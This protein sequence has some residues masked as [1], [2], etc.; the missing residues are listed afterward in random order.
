MSPCINMVFVS[1]KKFI[2]RSIPHNSGRN[3]LNKK[4][5]CI[6]SSTTSNV[7]KENTFS[8]YTN[9]N[10]FSQDIIIFILKMPIFV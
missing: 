5:Y 3:K 2:T 7:R 10:Q 9:E 4:I 1:L 6:G 8:L